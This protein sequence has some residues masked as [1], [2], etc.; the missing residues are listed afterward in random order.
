MRELEEYFIHRL[1]T[2]GNREVL[3]SSRKTIPFS[4]LHRQW[5]GFLKQAEPETL[6]SGFPP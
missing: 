2:T 3:T 6:C 4:A 5:R 1:Q